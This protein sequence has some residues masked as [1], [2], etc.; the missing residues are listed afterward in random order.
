M[1]DK[2]S[3][4]WIMRPIY[5]IAPCKGLQ[6]DAAQSAANQARNTGANLW[7][8]WRDKQD[9]NIEVK[10]NGKFHDF[11]PNSVNFTS[12]FMVCDRVFPQSR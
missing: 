1:I 4:V 11:P 8:P 2:Q 5:M 6:G 3:Y 12:N 7:W 10:F 9:L